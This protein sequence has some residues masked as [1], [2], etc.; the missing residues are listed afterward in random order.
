MLRHVHLG[1]DFV[2]AA[3]ATEKPSEFASTATTI[4]FVEPLEALLAL[5]AVGVVS[6]PTQGIEVPDLDQLYPPS[7]AAMMI[8]YFAALQSIH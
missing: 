6:R 5:I 1:I 8:D 2:S 7:A 4:A 3:M